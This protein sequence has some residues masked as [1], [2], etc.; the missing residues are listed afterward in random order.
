MSADVLIERRDSGDQGTFG[1]LTTGS[2][3]LYTGELPDRSNAPSISCIPAGRYR[4]VWAW[5]PR[6]RRYTYRLLDVPARSGVLIHSANLC[7]DIARGYR[8]HLNGCIALGERLGTLEGQRA[9]LLS[10]PAV[11]RFEEFMGRQSFELEIR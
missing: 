7:G 11:R 4:V 6:F 1:L 10:A 3:T 5:S 8:S 2:L 9:V